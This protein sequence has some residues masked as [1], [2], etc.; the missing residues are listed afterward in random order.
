MSLEDL[1]RLTLGDAARAI[2]AKRIKSRDLVDAC[3]ARIAARDPQIKAFVRLAADLRAQT[4]R[5][6][7]EPP[8]G[9]LHGVPVAVKD[10]IDTADMD[11]EYGSAIRRG[12]RPMRD[13]ACV[14]RLRGAGAIVI[15]KT[16]TTEFAHVT[17]AATVN[18]LDPQRTPGGSSSGSA[19]AVADFMVPAALGTQTGGSVIRP[20]AFCGLFGFKSSVGRTDVAGVHELAGAL[21]T[22]G[23][24]ARSAAD[25]TLLG[26]VLLTPTR[27]GAPLAPRPRIAAC[28]TP[29]D[30]A[31]SPEAREA[32][33]SAASRLREAGAEVLE[34]ALPPSFGDLNLVHRRVCSVEAARALAPYEAENAELLSPAL[35]DFIEEGRA[36]AAGY[37]QAVAKAEARR[38]DV[39]A[40]MRDVD[41][42]LVLAAPGEAPIGL[43][44]TGDA[45]FSLFWSLLQLP[46]ATLPTA[47]GLNGMPIGIQ[48]IGRRDR[49]EEL[50]AVSRWTARALGL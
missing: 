28:R 31:A 41:A 3:L 25:L 50:L 33:A 13:A 4:A 48:L 15:G 36:N 21:D 1:T 24:L 16:A 23:W 38:K 35:R 6:D 20:A 30:A 44:S 27:I 19:A 12:F 40:L 9:P 34:R 42:F 7:A 11:T 37:A 10:L 47:R 26:D 8:R 43:A 29:F 18:P 39:A 32:V 2:A 49:D 46:C 5:A 45:T 17:P 14:A 22:V